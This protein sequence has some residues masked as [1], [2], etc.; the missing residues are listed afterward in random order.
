MIT[1]GARP[2]SQDLALT[3]VFTSSQTGNFRCISELLYGY[4]SDLPIGRE[5]IQYLLDTIL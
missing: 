3:P 1:S 5:T 2:A 4:S